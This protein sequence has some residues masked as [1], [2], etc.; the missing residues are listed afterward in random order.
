F[1]QLINA[2]VRFV[3]AT[4]STLLSLNKLTSGSKLC[5]VSSIW[6]DAIRPNKLSY[7]V[8]KAAL[9]G[10]VKS[11]A[12][13]LADKEIFVNAVLPG[14]IDTPMTRSVLSDGQVVNV[15][16]RTGFARLVQ[17]NELAE[18]IFFLCSDANGCVT[19]QSIVADLGFANVRPV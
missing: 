9:N 12:L 7:A 15:Q 4:L 2:N 11:V 10:L 16:N 8:S 13:D 19:G 17:P 5:V 1:D 3:A 14:V 6:Q 18:L